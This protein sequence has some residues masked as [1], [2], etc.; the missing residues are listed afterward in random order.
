MQQA[1][2]HRAAPTP[3]PK[4]DVRHRARSD[5]EQ[6]FRIWARRVSVQQLPGSWAAGESE[7]SQKSA[8]FTR[9]YQPGFL[10]RR[11]N[12]HSAAQISQ[13]AARTK[14]PGLE[15]LAF[16]RGFTS[17]LSNDK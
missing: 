13:L 16:V 9:S 1:E 2:Q 11:A 8:S 15:A 14:K 10:G 6:L 4:S 7:Q 5:T 17:F 3:T 12:N